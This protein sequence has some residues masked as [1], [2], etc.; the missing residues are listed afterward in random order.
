MD[1]STSDL[2]QQYTVFA[3]N[4]E[5][6]LVAKHGSEKASRLFQRMSPSQFETVCEGS[7]TDGLKR[8]WLAR[9]QTRAGTRT[10]GEAA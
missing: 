5:K 6:Q 10:G 2:Y 7:S 4:L 9:L 8:Q 1:K 3:D